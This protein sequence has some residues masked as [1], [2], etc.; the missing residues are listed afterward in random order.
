MFPSHLRQQE[1]QKVQ[2]NSTMQ[3]SPSLEASLKSINTIVQTQRSLLL[4]ADEPTLSTLPGKKV[5]DW[6]KI[7]NLTIHPIFKQRA[8]YFKSDTNWVSSVQVEQ[9]AL[10]C[11]ICNLCQLQLRK[12]FFLIESFGVVVITN[13]M[14]IWS[15]DHQPYD[16]TINRSGW[17]YKRKTLQRVGFCSLYQ[18]QLSKLVQRCASSATVDTQRGQTQ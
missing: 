8:Q 13:P 17:K 14:V 3:M 1:V 15:C 12:F 6:T 5:I 9:C 2:I 7:W 16:D 4:E 11:Q 10:W 18:L